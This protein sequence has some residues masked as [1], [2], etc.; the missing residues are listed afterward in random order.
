MSEALAGPKRFYTE[1]EKVAYTL[2]MASRKLR[3]Y[4]TA[5]KITVPASLPLRNMFENREATGRMAK[6]AA[7]IAPLMIVFMARI[8]MKSQA[9]ADFIAEWTP[10]AEAPAEEPSDPVWIAYCDGA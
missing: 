1:M 3:H 6:W 5:H 8:A 7:E 9:L 10:L 4:F 2:V